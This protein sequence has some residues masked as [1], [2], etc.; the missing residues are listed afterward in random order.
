MI[1]SSCGPPCPVTAA[2]SSNKPCSKPV[3]PCSRPDRQDVTWTD[4]LVEMAHR[5]F[6]TVT[7]PV[8]RD[9]FRVHLHVNADPT[10]D[11]GM[12]TATW[13]DGQAMPDTIRDLIICDGIVIPEWWRN[14]KPYAQGRQKRVVPE[15]MRHHITHRDR[16][17]RVPGCT[18]ERWVDIHH[19]VHWQPPHN[20]NTEPANLVSCAGTIIGCI[21]TATSTSAVTPNNPT[22][23]RSPT[24]AADRS[25]PHPHHHR[26]HHPTP[27]APTGHPPAN[28]STPTASSGTPTANPSSNTKTAPAD[29]GVVS[30]YI[31]RAEAPMG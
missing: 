29:A 16:G 17:C 21:T 4:A 15:W 22:G 13:A 20:G 14:G 23:S 19:I 9:R 7:Q 25:D 26:D 11:G 18:A 27:P 8:R 31:T 5:S 10:V 1:S 3:T 2:G 12:D 24:P 30:G 28:T 6:D